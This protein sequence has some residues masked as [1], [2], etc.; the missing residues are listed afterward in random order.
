MWYEVDRNDIIVAL[1]DDWDA[2][3]NDHHDPKLLSR[4]LIGKPLSDFISGDVS[5]MFTETMIA[6]ARVQQKPII[7]PYRCDSPTRKRRMQMILTPFLEGHVRV[8]HQ[9]VTETPWQHPM[10]MRTVGTRQR[11]GKIKRCSMCN[12]LLDGEAWVTQDAY[13]A[14]HIQTNPESLAVFY[15]IC[16]NCSQREH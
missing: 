15:G 13:F 7:K 6:S 8:E 12:N 4:S 10:H 5:M 3:I 2:T 11:V 14:N 9:Q 1:S 16:P